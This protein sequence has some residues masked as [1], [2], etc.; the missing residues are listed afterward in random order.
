MRASA[1]AASP[2]YTRCSSEGR[3]G[4]IRALNVPNSKFIQT[5][6]NL[7]EVAVGQAVSRRIMKSVVISDY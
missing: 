3:A 2:F 1:V 5:T 4:I 7:L 6:N